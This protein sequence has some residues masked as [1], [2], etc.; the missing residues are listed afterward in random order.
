M[1]LR[2]ALFLACSAAIL[3]QSPTAPLRH[4]YDFET[5]LRPPVPPDPLELVTCPALHLQ[6]APQR[7]PRFPC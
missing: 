1:R 6:D 5:I 3:A 4:A 2:T 7:M